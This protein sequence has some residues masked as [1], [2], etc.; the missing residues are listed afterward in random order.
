MTAGWD[1]MVHYWDGR[2]DKPA[3]SVNLGQRA[4]CMDVHEKLA[5]VALA[6]RKILVYDLNNPTQVFRQRMSTLK[7][8]T[9][10]I[11]CF[12][13]QNKMGF[14]VGSIEG[15]CAVMHVNEVD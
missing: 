14:V 5:V 13:T 6:D 7:Y 2:T 11:A 12:P 10:S 4:F 9:R 8:Q 3:S 1:S 15:R